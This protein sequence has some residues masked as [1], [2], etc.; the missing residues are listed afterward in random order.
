M[1]AL[2][3]AAYG[4]GEIEASRKQLAELAST[5]ED[6][7][8][9]ALARL[10]RL[11]ALV[12]IGRGRYALNPAVAWSGSRASREQAVAAQSEQKPGLRVVEPA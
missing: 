11:G 2:S 3:Y 10:E 5:T 6:E 8:S 4:T 9:R 12:R 1:A 7:A